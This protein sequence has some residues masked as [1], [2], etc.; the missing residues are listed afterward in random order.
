MSLNAHPPIEDGEAHRLA[1]EI[2]K[3]LHGLTISEAEW[4]LRLA[5]GHLH[6]STR[7]DTASPDFAARV[8]ELEAAAHGA[9]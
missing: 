9:A 1:L 5:G 3:M 4:V 7:V 6:G 2:V 8:Q